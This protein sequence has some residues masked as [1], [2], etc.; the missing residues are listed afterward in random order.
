LFIQIGETMIPTQELIGN[1]QTRMVDL[2]GEA[3]SVAKKAKKYRKLLGG[4][5][6]YASK[7][8]SLRSEAVNT[9]REMGRPGSAAEV[10][11]DNIVDEVFASETDYH[12]RLLT[13]R[14]LTHI[15]E[16]EDFQTETP[17]PQSQ[18]NSIFPVDLLHKTGKGY[19]ITICRQMNGCFTLRWYD[20]CAVMM[21]RLVENSIIEAY[22]GNGISQQAFDDQG[23]FVPLTEL[24]RRALSEP[25]W[26]LS[27]NAKR[28]LPRLRDIGHI[29]AHSRR[30]TAQKSDIE[31]IQADC[32]VVVEELLH[33]AKL[34]Q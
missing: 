8:T 19:L 16:T 25:K 26:N 11:I 15:L 4:D 2:V 31:N 3:L 33:I 21:R 17:A 30:F 29:S 6:Y 34:L 13:A 24:I 7:M 27:R 5:N 18:E 20:A 9:L 12:E 23:E 22:E 14:K 1:G 32:R 28:G 10:G